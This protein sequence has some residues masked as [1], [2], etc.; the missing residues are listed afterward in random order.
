MAMV[1]NSK[2]AL[3]Y[4]TLVVTKVKYVPYVQDYVYVC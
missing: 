2:Q 4:F 1:N 3:I